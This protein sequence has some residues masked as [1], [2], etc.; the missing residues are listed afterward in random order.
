[1]L[2]FKVIN[3]EFLHDPCLQRNYEL[4]IFLFTHPTLSDVTAPVYCD[5]KDN[6]FFDVI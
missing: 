3:S 1:M 6:A 4:E 2:N 5:T